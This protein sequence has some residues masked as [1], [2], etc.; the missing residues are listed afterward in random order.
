LDGEIAQ[1][2]FE[3]VLVQARP[4]ALL[5]NEYLTVHTTLNSEVRA[6]QAR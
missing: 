3:R 4:Q 1:A 5:S 2:L 6:N